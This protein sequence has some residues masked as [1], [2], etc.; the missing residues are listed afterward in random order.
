[1]SINP[2]PLS[3][4]MYPHHLLIIFVRA[5]EKDDKDKELIRRSK[6]K[7]PYEKHN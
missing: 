2:H 3:Y 1:M 6:R 7:S 4:D 5:N